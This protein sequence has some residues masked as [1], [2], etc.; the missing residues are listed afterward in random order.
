MRRLTTGRWK[1]PSLW[2]KGAQS[3]S[4]RRPLRSSS[5]SLRSSAPPT[6][7]PQIAEKWGWSH[8][9]SFC[10][11]KNRALIRT[12]TP[13]GIW[14]TDGDY[15][16]TESHPQLF[17]LS[18][19]LFSCFSYIC[20]VSLS[21]S[22]CWSRVLMACSSP[23]WLRWG[24]RRCKDKH[25]RYTQH[26][27]MNLCI[28]F[29]TFLPALVCRTVCVE[30]SV[31]STSFLDWVG[32]DCCETAFPLVT[33]V[34]INSFECV[35]AHVAGFWQREVDKTCYSYIINCVC[36]HLIDLILHKGTGHSHFHWVHWLSV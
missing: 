1:P 29:K 16:I 14:D 30:M 5:P 24:Y 32:V 8:D 11:R 15:F 34:L 7:H 4:S 6:L 13:K 19:H 25:I 35:L 10:G 3:C 9:P 21:S 27:R 23:L 18:L 12:T 28:L 2:W 31:C 20:W 26:Y 33:V 17:V 36:V 22:S